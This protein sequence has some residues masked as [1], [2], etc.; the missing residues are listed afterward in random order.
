MSRVSH[1]DSHERPFVSIEDLLF[2]LFFSLSLDECYQSTHA[3]TILGMQ[4]DR[5]E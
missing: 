2:S 3:F 1:I 4:I 5:V